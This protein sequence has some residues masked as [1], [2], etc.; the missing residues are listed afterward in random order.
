MGKFSEREKM[1]NEEFDDLFNIDLGASLLAH[2]LEQRQKE[3]TLNDVY[4]MLD[5]DTA[6]GK[7]EVIDGYVWDADHKE[8]IKN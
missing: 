7:D 5:I 3:V 6:C 4:K 1:T 8:I 2:D